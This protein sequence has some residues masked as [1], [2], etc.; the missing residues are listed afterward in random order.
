MGKSIQ[1]N[2]EFQEINLERRVKLFSR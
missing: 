1:V 2:K